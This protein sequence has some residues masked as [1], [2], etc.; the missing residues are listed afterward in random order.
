MMNPFQHSDLAGLIYLYLE[1]NFG[2]YVHQEEGGD[3]ACMLAEEVSRVYKIKLIRDEDAIH[4]FIRRV[5]PRPSK[6]GRAS[7]HRRRK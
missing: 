6:K 7:R 4:K 5:F 2:R 1:D 3:L